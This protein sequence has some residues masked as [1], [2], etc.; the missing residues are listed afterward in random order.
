MPYLH[1][2]RRRVPT[3]YVDCSV[4]VGMC[5]ETAMLA[6]KARLAF[7]ALPVYGSAFRTG[8]R[9]IS[10]IDLVQMSPAFFEFIGKD[11]LEAKPTLV[12]DRAIKPCF[13]PH[14]A[15][16]LFNGS[17]RGCRHVFDAQIF[18]HNR[19][20]ATRNVERSFVM[21][22][23][24]DARPS[25]RELGTTA[26]L[27]QVS[28]RA[29]L[30]AR[31]HPLCGTVTMLDGFKRARNGQTLSIGQ[32]ERVSNSTINPDRRADID[33]CG[34]FNFAS[35]ADMP[36]QRIVRYSRVLD[37][38]TQRPRIS[39]LNPTNF[40]QANCRPFAA[41]SFNFNLA[42]L[43]TE[44]VVQAFLTRIRI[45]RTT[46]KEICERSVK[47]TQ[48]LLLA[49]LRDSGNPVVLSTQRCQFEGLGNIAQAL[50]GSRQVLPPPIPALFKG[51]VIDQPTHTGELPKQH[52][53]LGIWHQLKT[54]AAN[55]HKTSVMVSL[56]IGNKLEETDIHYR[57]HVEYDLHAHLV[58]VKKY[59][60]EISPEPSLW[61]L[62]S[63]FTKNCDDFEADLIEFNRDD[64]D[65]HLL[66][67]YPPKV[68]LSKLVIPLKGV[69]SRLLRECRPEVS[70]PYRKWVLWS[71]SYFVASCGGALLS[72]I[73]E[74]VHNQRREGVL[75]TRP[76]GLGFRAQVL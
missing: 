9:G 57:M 44:G 32:G 22:I 3:Q 31:K 25:S 59:R 61:V 41:V 23:A 62:L 29:T 40:R 76:E 4:V 11:G 53:L 18:K 52:L 68:S 14:H 50:S 26:Q 21:P 73:A 10:G 58:F 60:R 72:I 20:I 48:R 34:M 37:R 69:S 63:N 16:R 55:D 66:V 33:G 15:A 38:A 28:H 43:K 45:P 74:Y 35:K 8:L 56:S 65:I 70:G 17:A 46:R 75:T 2:H 54:E 67:N 12:E 19:A 64:D 49:R 13:L 5:A 39:K 30:A 71:P 51:E 27:L 47:V 1:A 7:A 6:D 42:P 36:S 24:S